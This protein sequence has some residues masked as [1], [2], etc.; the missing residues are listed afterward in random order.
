MIKLIDDLVQSNTHSRF[1]LWL[2]GGADSAMLLVLLLESIKRSKADKSI[3][4]LHGWDT[5]R[6]VAVSYEASDQIV[7]VLQNRYPGIRLKDQYV[8]PY[9]K[10]EKSKNK[11]HNPLNQYLLKTG[12]ADCIFDCS[13]LNPP[14]LILGEE[15][16][17]TEPETYRNT[18][19]IY[20]PLRH[21]DKK[22]IA[23][24]Y[25][26]Y[27]LMDDLFPLTVSCIGDDIKPCRKC[28]WCKE[29]HWAF[30]YYD[31]KKR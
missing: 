2:S 29:K 25:Y 9:Y 6:T 20:K 21:V 28:D 30:G 5:M 23:K 16:T 26:K 12:I 22:F 19:R 18:Q 7:K 31:G 3:L 1:A 10:T 13:T 24:L 14:H 27:D 8:L 17:N 4:P 15:R 11:Y